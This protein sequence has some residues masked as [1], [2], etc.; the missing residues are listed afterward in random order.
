[1]PATPEKVIFS[2]E[3]RKDFALMSNHLLT[4][5]TDRYL[6]GNMTE[7]EQAE[8]EKLCQSNAEVSSRVNEH[9][10]FVDILKSYGERTALKQHLNAI[11]EQMDVAQMMED[12]TEK[13]SWVIQMW[14]NHHSKIS[15]AASIAVFAILGT[16]F[17]SGYFAGKS[18]TQML[19]N[20]IESAENKTDRLASTINETLHPHSRVTAPGNYTG[21]GFAISS[22]GY[23]VTNFHVVNGGDSL[24]VQN[25]AGDS[26][27]AKLVYSDP[28]YDVA[29]LKVDDP[30]FKG[31]GALPYSFKNSTTDLGENVY[32]MGF[33]GDSLVCGK[34]YLA[35][36]AGLHGDTLAYQVSIPVN[37]GNSGGPLCDSKGNIIGIIRSRGAQLEGAAFAV[38]TRYLLKAIQNIPADSLSS[39]KLA[40][41]SG[42]NALAGLEVPQQIKKIRNYVFM[43]KVY[44]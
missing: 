38:K 36:A 15:V 8:F 20:K 21:T 1:M 17:F 11:H 37:P 10:N 25:A 44:N 27:H 13:P 19:K 31:L 28:K 18:E 42:K 39:A 23:L 14:R 12:V 9:L 41:N 24:Y 43:V 29:I 32:T 33:P 34:G 4:E 7:A 26:Y 16:L 5:L 3:I 22:N 2:A 40:S 35:S 30:A 6:N